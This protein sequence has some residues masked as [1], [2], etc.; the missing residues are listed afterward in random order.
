MELIDYIFST[1]KTR[2]AN[3][4]VVWC[5]CDYPI[6]LYNVDCIEVSIIKKGLLEVL[7][8]GQVVSN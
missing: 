6:I 2:R 3:K 7:A 4:K 8:F 1:S 5:V